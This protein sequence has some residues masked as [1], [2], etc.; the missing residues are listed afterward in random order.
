M[1]RE[2]RVRVATVVLH[3]M[4]RRRLRRRRAAAW[5]LNAAAQD[6][7]LWGG[8]KRQRNGQRIWAG[9]PGAPRPRRGEPAARWGLGRSMTGVAQLRAPRARRASAAA[10]P[11]G[12][13]A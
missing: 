6:R 7:A 4:L 1:R 10:V 9:A 3:D 8:R 5:V 13:A 12:S 11:V 2:V